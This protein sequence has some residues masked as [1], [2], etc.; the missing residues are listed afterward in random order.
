MKLLSR[1][2]RKPHSLNA[3]K[4]EFGWWAGYQG[5][6]LIGP[7]RAHWQE[8]LFGEPDAYVEAEVR[9]HGNKKATQQT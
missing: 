1:I 2:V 8:H 4:N 3:A 6:E 5:Y 9:R 7:I